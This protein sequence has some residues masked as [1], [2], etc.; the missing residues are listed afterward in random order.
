MLNNVTG[1]ILYILVKID[2]LWL[3]SMPINK[4]LS[5][6]YTLNDQVHQRLLSSI[7]QYKESDSAENFQN[8]EPVYISRHERFSLP[9][10]LYH[11]AVSSSVRDHKCAH[12]F[13]ESRSDT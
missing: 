1:A 11:S 4:F 5:P 12:G 2:T 3:I 6:P 9:N 7:E 10:S 13:F 8:I